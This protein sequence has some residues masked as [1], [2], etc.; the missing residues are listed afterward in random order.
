MPSNQ[1]LGLRLADHELT[2]PSVQTNSPDVLVHPPSLLVDAKALAAILSVS[3]ATVWRMDAGGKL[4]SA[5]RPSPG[6]KRWRRE[7]IREWI[8]V[9]CPCRKDWEV[10][11]K[12]NR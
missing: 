1:T 11:K 4:P 8:D 10:M 5:V 12:V 6:V 2:H 9:G 7:E 3:V